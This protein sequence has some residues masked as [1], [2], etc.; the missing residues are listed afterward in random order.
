[1]ND[2]IKTYLN[3]KFLSNSSFLKVHNQLKNVLNRQMEWFRFFIGVIM[4]KKNYRK[5]KMVRGVVVRIYLYNINNDDDGLQ[6]VTI[7]R[8]LQYASSYHP[9]QQFTSTR[10]R[11]SKKHMIHYFFHHCI[12]LFKCFIG[13]S[14][15][16]P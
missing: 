9:T 11:L 6:S 8:Y 10:V 7:S 3:D 13:F 5:K 14:L 4:R 16:S 12:C 2:I 15:Y 1:M